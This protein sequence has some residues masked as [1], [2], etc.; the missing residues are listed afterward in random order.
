MCSGIVQAQQDCPVNLMCATIY[1][2]KTQDII[3]IISN[4]STLHSYVGAYPASVCSHPA[5][6]CCH[7]LV[8][9]RRYEKQ[10][11]S[12]QYVRV[13]LPDPLHEHTVQY[14]HGFGVTCM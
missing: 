10:L 1:Y 14:D 6:T 7:K 4:L 11:E 5:R 12:L 13:R 2:S 9:E 3:L 8:R